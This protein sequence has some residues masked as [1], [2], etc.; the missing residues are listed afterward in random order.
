MK[1][2]E[3]RVA[4]PA[5][6]AES[7]DSFIYSGF[8]FHNKNPCSNAQAGKYTPLLLCIRDR[9]EK[10][11][12]LL[13]YKQHLSDSYWLIPCISGTMEHWNTETLE[14]WNTE[15]LELWNIETL[16]LKIK[17]KKQK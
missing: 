12:E 10:A 3:Y 5:P 17:D 8:L 7:N 1:T 4:F 2:I 15:T 16:E 14:H 6:A 13:T 9:R 11:V